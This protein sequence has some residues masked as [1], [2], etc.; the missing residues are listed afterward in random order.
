VDKGS[1]EVLLGRG[2]TV[3]EIAGRFGKHPSTVAYWMRKHGLA[4][5]NRE[6]HSAKGALSR[7]QLKVLVDAGV[8]VTDIASAV[9][10]SKTTVRHWLRRYELQTRRAI[11]RRPPDLADQAKQNGLAEVK[12]VCRR[13]GETEFC[14]EG[15]GYYRCKRCRSESVARHRRRLKETLVREAGGACVLC[16]YKRCMAALEFHHLDP[17]Q[18][19]LTI[20]RNGATLSL[21]VLREEARKCA[22]VCSN[23]HAELGVGA[24]TIPDTVGGAPDP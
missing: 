12:M 10:R 2:M 3:E 21:A 22:L 6:K 5:V 18:K 4:A 19:R 24:A 23:C 8:S 9:G 11:E 15:R 16:G 20:S 13:H 1:L 17:S 7:Q 14:L